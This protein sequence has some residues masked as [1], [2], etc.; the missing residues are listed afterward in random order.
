M[1]DFAEPNFPQ[2]SLLSLSEATM[3][4]IEQD[5]NTIHQFIVENRA[6]KLTEGMTDTLAACA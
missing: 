3:L 1:D 5:W 4:R 6:D 2:N